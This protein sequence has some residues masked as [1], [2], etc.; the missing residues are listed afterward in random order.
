M[1]YPCFQDSLTLPKLPLALSAPAGAGPPTKDETSA[2]RPGSP[3]QRSVLG[4]IEN[5][6]SSSPQLL[7]VPETP[8]SQIRLSASSTPGKTHLSPQARGD[9]SLIYQS[10]VSRQ[11]SRKRDFSGPR[12]RLI[13]PPQESHNA[14]RS[15]KPDTLTAPSL[16]V[17]R[18]VKAAGSDVR[19]KG[20]ERSSR[21]SG[22]RETALR[23]GTVEVKTGSP[24][25]LITEPKA[26]DADACG[27]RN[28][29]CVQ[30]AAAHVQKHSPATATRAAVT[31]GEKEDVGI[32]INS[33][34]GGRDEGTVDPG[35]A[36]GIGILCVCV[37]VETLI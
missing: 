4:V 20:S 3:F 8:T 18:P 9:V 1:Y 33:S 14:K 24:S 23:N 30:A 29:A 5:L 36:E 15:M 19:H 28:T 13:S 35:G 16:N 22:I 34:K 17:P 2:F 10:P 25:S 27:E 32:E 21:D 37:C 31:S 26:T 11:T 7:S 12:K 6:L